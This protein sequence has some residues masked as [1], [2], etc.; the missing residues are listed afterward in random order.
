ME[1]EK[2]SVHLDPEETAHL[3]RKNVFPRLLE[4]T[5][6]GTQIIMADKIC[7]QSAEKSYLSSLPI[8]Y[9]LKCVQCQLFIKG[10]SH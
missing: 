2:E 5:E 10:L 4:Q 3:F 6:E 9:L 7:L 1:K 8:K